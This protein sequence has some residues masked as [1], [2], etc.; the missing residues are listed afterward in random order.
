MD[1]AN[2]VGIYGAAL[3][4]LLAVL[5]LNKHLKSGVRV[6]VR[7]VDLYATMY[8][9]MMPEP[10]VLVTVI[11][12]NDFSVLVNSLTISGASTSASVFANTG[13]GGGWQLPIEIPP[14]RAKDFSLGWS[15]MKTRHIPEISPDNDSLR[16]VFSVGLDTGKTVR[17]KP[18][19]ITDRIRKPLPPV[20][21][22]T[23]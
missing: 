2:V 15:A 20:V 3:A 18:T 17:S 16:L 23:K 6:S 19:L 1:I 21:R 9:T 22:G 11:N 4:T 13:E 14:H 12:T 7:L 10:L 8:P 5:E